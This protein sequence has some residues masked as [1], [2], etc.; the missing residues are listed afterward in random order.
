[1][2]AAVKF[3]LVHYTTLREAEDHA[4]K[5]EWLKPAENKVL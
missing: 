5:E 1:M 4:P 3:A 2:P